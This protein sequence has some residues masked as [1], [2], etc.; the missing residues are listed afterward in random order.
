VILQPRLTLADS[1]EYIRSLGIEM[2]T[3]IDV[4][5]GFGTP[6]LYNAFPTAHLILVDPLLRVGNYTHLEAGLHGRKVEFVAAAAGQFL[7]KTVMNVHD[8]LESSSLL[9]EEEGQH[10]DG[11]QLAV[12]VTTIDQICTEWNLDSPIVIKIDVQGYELEVLKGATETLTKTDV[13][14]VEISL[15]H[16][17]KRSPTLC[18]V[19]I[20]MEKHGFAPYDFV[21]QLY[22][23]LDNALAQIDVVLVK[24][25]GVFRSSHCFASPVQRAAFMG[26]AKVN[27][28]Q[29][30]A[31]LH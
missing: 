6:D 26:E 19:L 27:R 23:P 9:K 25:C 24:T 2:S 31:R 12:E 17:Y 13:V 22:R 8:D 7:G 21:G 3:I 1:L 20:F 15:F 11:N 29:N 18:E 16:F 4:G 28:Y 10:C 30:I 14:I 5:V